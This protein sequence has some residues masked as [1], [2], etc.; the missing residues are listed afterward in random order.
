MENYGSRVIDTPLGEFTIYSSKDGISKI[1]PFA[2]K[3]FDNIGKANLDEAEKWF[4]SY[5]DKNILKIP[6][7]DLTILTAFRK[8]VTE[9]LVA[10]V[11][12][13]TVTS[14]SKLALEINNES[15]IRAVGTVMKNN[16]WP[17]LVPC[18]RVIMQ[19][20]HIGKYNFLNGTETKKWLL[21]FEGSCV[22]NYRV[23]F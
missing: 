23:N 10:K 22:E 19:N 1:L 6:K 20:N 13:G 11:L 18:H 9:I 3:E 8:Q 2:N 4:F 16:P 21:E 14:Y 7:L 15:A 17:I 12:F 5:F